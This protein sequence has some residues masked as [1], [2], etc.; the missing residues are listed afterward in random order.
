M[1]VSVAALA[2]VG[3][4]VVNGAAIEPRGNKLVT[5]VSACIGFAKL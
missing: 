3:A 4:A 1:K 2:A 5:S